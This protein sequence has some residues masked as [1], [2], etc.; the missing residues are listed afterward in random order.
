MIRVELLHGQSRQ[1]P[2]WAG[3]AL[4]AIAL[5]GGLYGLN[6]LY[7]FGQI[8]HSSSDEMA[9]SQELWQ[10]ETQSSADSPVAA[11]EAQSEQAS[12][13]PPAAP[14]G[15]SGGWDDAPEQE[16]SGWGDATQQESA[17]WDDAPQQQPVAESA[18][19]VDAPQQQPLPVVQ[20][21]VP[22]A[23]PAPVSTS[24]AANDLSQV[25][26][27]DGDRPG[28][29]RHVPRRSAACQWAVRIN[30]RVPTGVRLVSLT[31]SAAGEYGLEGTSAS[32]QS[33]RTFNDILQGL[34]SQVTLSSWPEGKATD[35]ILR[36]AFEGRFAEQPTR[37]LATLSPDQAK[38]LFGKIA[39]WA[40]ESGLDG[41]SIKKPI[42]IPLPPARMHQR[43][44][45]WGTGS[46][47]QIGAFLQKLQQVEE[48]AALGEVVLMPVQ[49]DEHGWA[50]AR[51]Y[52][53]VD[54]VVGMP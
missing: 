54:V 1:V 12:S 11:S 41:L 50:E 8:F 45:L 10:D 23:P 30:E 32:Q 17:G 38:R 42:A 19:P 49:S 5:C 14:A 22:V 28:G 26:A 47:Q 36:F 44:K 25:S 3:P 18:S 43:Q 9:V 20:E 6:W 39:H 53:A 46:Y 52:A 21:A 27:G 13:A 33:L 4:F 2:P 7:P 51:L 48:I 15:S 29:A 34:P 35:R 37:E 24:L 16:T 31:C 40:D